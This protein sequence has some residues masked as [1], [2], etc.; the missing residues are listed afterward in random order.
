VVYLPYLDYCLYAIGLLGSP[1]DDCPWVGLAMRPSFH[2]HSMDVVAP[3]PAL[4]WIKKALFFR[5]LRHHSLRC[6]LTIDEP[7]VA[8][9]V[10]KQRDARRVVFFPEPAELGDLPEPSA[11]KQEF[12]M[13]LSRKLIL[14]YGAIS[15]RKGVVELL[16]ALA[17][18]CFPPAVDVLLA[19]KV[20][21]PAIREMLAES[22]VRALIDQGRVR[23]I[24][25]YIAPREESTLFAAADIVWM[26][27]RDHYNASGILVQAANAGRPVLACEKG[28]IGWQTR[29]HGL[30]RTV[31]PT[32][33]AE[34]AAAVRA[35]L[36]NPPGKTDNT[37]P[38]DP[39]RPATFDEA[40]DMLAHVLSGG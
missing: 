8:Y 21:E 15:A 23:V 30:G 40:Q 2:Y 22:R 19:G 14:L 34:V 12:G 3:R 9:V 16:R 35:L 37:K 18:P 32:D 4:A 7:L 1:F 20:V 31:N 28:V 29:R 13:A 33:T 38:V 39:W 24:D 36:D 26:G 17:T 11:A 6:L 27:Y 10:T 25:R 5:M